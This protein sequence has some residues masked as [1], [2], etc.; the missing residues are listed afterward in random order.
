MT[1]GRV[2]HDRG[3]VLEGHREDALSAAD[4]DGPEVSLA[5]TADDAVHV[6]STVDACRDAKYR[7]STMIWGSGMS[8]P[9]YDK[10]ALPYGREA[11]HAARQR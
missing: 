7:Q 2:A 6:L 4:A 11:L 8:V 5:V 1:I 10:A 9:R 3:E